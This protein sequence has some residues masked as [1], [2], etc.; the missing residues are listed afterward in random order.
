MTTNK[1]KFNVWTQKVSASAFIWRS[2]PKQMMLRLFCRLLHKKKRQKKWRVDRRRWESPFLCSC[3]IR[4]CCQAAV[5]GCSQ[6]WSAEIFPD[7]WHFLR[8]SWSHTCTWIFHPSLSLSLHFR[9]RDGLWS[10]APLCNSW[11]R[12]F[13]KKKYSFMNNVEHWLWQ[14]LEV[15]K[16]TSRLGKY[17]RSNTALTPR[18]VCACVCA[19]FKWLY[20]SYWAC[21]C[22]REHKG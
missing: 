6:A 22:P 7:E 11:Q 15:T 16:Q 10:K 17:W 9:A 19:H 20:H 3:L 14:N 13:R 1:R 8:C 18:C 5:S 2:I 21:T 4:F 12:R